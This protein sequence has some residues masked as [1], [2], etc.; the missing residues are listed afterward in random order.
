MWWEWGRNCSRGVQAYLWEVSG[1]MGAQLFLRCAGLPVRG[2]WWEWGRN[3]SWGV[4]PYLSEVSGGMGAQLFFRCAGL[5]VRGQWRDG[6]AT[7]LEMCRPTCEK[8]VLR[9]GVTVL[10]VCSPTC[11]RSVL[12]WGRNCSRGLQ[13]YL[14]EVCGGSEGATVL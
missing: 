8:S 10:E 11:E 12:G 13:P 5:L 1:G 2:M 7:V 4:Q 3:C 14:W 9:L 6:G